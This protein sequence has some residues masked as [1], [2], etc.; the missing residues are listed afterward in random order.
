[1]L[2]EGCAW[3]SETSEEDTWG[4]GGAGPIGRGGGFGFGSAAKAVA[5]AP[6]EVLYRWGFPAGGMPAKRA[7]CSEALYLACT[8]FCSREGPK[9]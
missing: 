9:S 4:C 3:G 5:D 1:M 7:S 8:R 6:A 2:L